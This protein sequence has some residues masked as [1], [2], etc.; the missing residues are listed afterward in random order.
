VVA[1]R[2]A[3]G[4]AV[5]P[6]VIFDDELHEYPYFATAEVYVTKVL[7]RTEFRGH[8]DRFKTS[9]AILEHLE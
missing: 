9:K 3:K 2:D 6:Q 4:K 7:D 1:V 5:R 8:C